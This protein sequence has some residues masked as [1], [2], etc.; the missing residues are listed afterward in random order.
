[1]SAIQ[2]VSVIGNRAAIWRQLLGDLS[3]LGV[4]NYATIAGIAQQLQAAAAS[5]GPV[6]AA[7]N[8]ATNRLNN[9]PPSI[10]LDAAI[11]QLGLS[12]T[13]TESNAD[14]VGGATGSALA[15]YVTGTLTNADVLIRAQTSLLNNANAFFDGSAPQADLA[16]AVVPYSTQIAA[17]LNNLENAAQLV[18]NAQ[19]GTVVGDASVLVPQL[20][21]AESEIVDALTDFNGAAPAP[22]TLRGYIGTA[23]IYGDAWRNGSIGGGSYGP[24][25][26]VPGFLA[27]I[28]GVAR[29]AGNYPAELPPGLA[30]QPFL[31]VLSYFPQL[32]V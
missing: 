6:L 31:D 30:A 19:S 28:D 12:V 15:G 29:T 11:V 7:I 2:T 21:T 10:D 17:V 24:I 4:T 22:T 3:G 8:D 18:D 14:S 1:M 9:A 26:G 20:Q 25:L 23:A 5:L 27:T 32:N 16:N 13:A